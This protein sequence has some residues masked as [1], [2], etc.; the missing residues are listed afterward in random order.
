LFLRLV[1]RGLR[2]LFEQFLSLTWFSL[3]WWL[4]VLTIVLGPPATVALYSMAD[5]RRQV[6]TPEFRDAVEV[7]RSAWRR[8]WGIFLFT[9]PLLLILVWNLYVFGGSA[10]LLAALTPLWLIMLVVLWILMLY[11]FAVAG[12]MESGTRNAF[13]GAM[14]V[15]VSRPFL[16]LTLSG[17]T[18]ALIVGMTITVLPIV[19]FGPAL[20]ACIVNRVVLFVLGVEVIDPSAPTTERAD[21]RARGINPD[22]GW[23]ARLRPG[24]GRTRQ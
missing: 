3:L 15:L 11:A 16:S 19:L 7:L 6:S 13:R 22:R 9:I 21:E 1:W 12:M 17:F 23:L 2:D 5:P 4:C 10:A 14:F 20:I 24:A 18:V 8:S